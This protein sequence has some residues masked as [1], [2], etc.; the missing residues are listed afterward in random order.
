[1]P[2]VRIALSAAT[3][4]ATALRIRELYFE[5]IGILTVEFLHTQ[6]GQNHDCV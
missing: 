6:W 2:L 3:Q 5:W 1:M 4:F